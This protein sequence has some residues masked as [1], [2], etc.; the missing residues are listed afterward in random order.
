M[1]CKG[2]RLDPNATNACLGREKGACDRL[3]RH[4]L[5]NP[6]F[7]PEPAQSLG[8]DQVLSASFAGRNLHL[9]I[10]AS[11]RDPAACSPLFSCQ[12][13]RNSTFSAVG[14]QGELRKTPLRGPDYRSR[15]PS[16]SPQGPFRNPRAVWAAPQQG[17]EIPRKCRVLRG[18]EP[19]FAG[20]PRPRNAALALAYRFV[21][22]RL[23]PLT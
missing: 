4:P 13:G 19:A 23:K 16:S 10:S 2:A 17:K 14:R 6:I 20:G 18:F 21:P 22:E 8:Q 9:V 7:E 12:T 5:I 3:Q 15:S 1:K 11:C